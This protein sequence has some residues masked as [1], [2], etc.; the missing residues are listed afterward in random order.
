LTETMPFREIRKK[1]QE[2]NAKEWE[3]FC[4]TASKFAG[5][6]QDQ[7]KQYTVKGRF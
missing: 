4:I 1:V 3:R 5:Y 7:E 2:E 6:G